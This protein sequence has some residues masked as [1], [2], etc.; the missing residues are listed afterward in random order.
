MVQYIKRF[1]NG[2]NFYGG[3]G[4]HNMIKLVKRPSKKTQ[5]RIDCYAPQLATRIYE[6]KIAELGYESVKK[7]M[8]MKEKKFEDK[9]KSNADLYGQ[10][11]V[12]F[13]EKGSGGNC[14]ITFKWS[15][16]F[17]DKTNISPSKYMVY[18]IDRL[19]T[20]VRFKKHFLSKHLP[21]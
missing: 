18:A 11:V 6:C 3:I 17:K 2:T 19:A 15:D 13:S 10:H 9:L 20:E 14:R 16:R 21:L 7:Q 12:H 1:G 4:E 5:R 8:G